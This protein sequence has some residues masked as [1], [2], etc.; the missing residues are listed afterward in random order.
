[1]RK[2]SIFTLVLTSIFALVSCSDDKDEVIKEGIVRSEL[3]FTEVKG[4]GVYPHGDHFHGL[5]DAT[6]E[7]K[8]TIKF[9]KN[10]KA[11]ENGHLHLESDAVYKL[12]LKTWDHTGKEVQNDY[13]LSKTVAD[14]YKAFIQGGNFKL[15]TQSAAESGAVFQ[16]RDLKYGDGNA[17]NGQFETIG[18][19]SYFTIGKDNE[20]L[21]QKVSYVL[22]KLNDGVKPK[23][24]R[25]DWNRLD[26]ASVFAGENVLELSFE[27]HAEKGHVH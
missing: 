22:R 16:P 9:D 15:N 25:L 3:T 19:L 26:Y 10:G 27:I 1:M 14:S 4:E 18:V 7:Q 13:L 6:E 23:I 5:A 12:E 21:S 20:G 2:L 17:V 11:T 24:T 8:V